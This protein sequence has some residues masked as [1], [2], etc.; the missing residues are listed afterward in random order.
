M[1]IACVA[2]DMICDA[3]DWQT[4]PGLTCHLQPPLSHYFDRP[5]Q[6]QLLW[7]VRPE[8][9][10]RSA[11][12]RRALSTHLDVP[13]WNRNGSFALSFEG[14]YSMAGCDLETEII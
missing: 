11:L 4:F 3:S 10:K 8:A 9:P 2:F 14:L 1:C 5:Y 6:G 12:R 13:G 7:P